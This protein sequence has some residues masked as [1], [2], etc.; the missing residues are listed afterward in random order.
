MAKNKNKKTSVGGLIVLVVLFTIAL[1]CL[2]VF[3]AGL[4]FGQPKDLYD[5][6]AEEGEPVKGEYVKLD[7]NAFLC[8]YAETEYK[9]NGIIPAGKIYH[10]VAR[11]DDGSVISVSFRSKSV[12]E[13]IDKIVNNTSAYYM[14][15]DASLLTDSIVVKGKLETVAGDQGI[16]YSKALM[17]YS[18]G[19]MYRM[20]INTTTKGTMLI[21]ILIVAI[22]DVAFVLSLL[23]AIKEKKNPQPVAEAPVQPMDSEQ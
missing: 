21:V 10:Y 13:K 22:I 3:N 19:E 6:I 15:G 5:V 7:A 17:G 8:E 9:I 14:T 12:K 4:I 2:I 18:D 11:L 16:Y 20:S 1:G 23:K